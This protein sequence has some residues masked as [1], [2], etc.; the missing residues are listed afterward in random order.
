MKTDKILLITLILLTIYGFIFTN[1]SLSDKINIKSEEKIDSLEKIITKINVEKEHYEAIL[2]NIL[3]KD[4]T[5]V[6]EAIKKL[7]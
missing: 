6:I 2:N 4:T 7:K 1:S 3:E 5:I